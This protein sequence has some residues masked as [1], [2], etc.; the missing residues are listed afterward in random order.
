MISVLMCTYNQERYIAQA[1]ESILMQKCSEPFELLIGD[2]CST[3]ATSRIVDEYQSRYPSIVRVIRPPH[4]TG[5]AENIIRLIHEAKYELIAICDGDDYWLRDD[6]L[7]KHLQIYK[8]RP[9]VGMICAKAKC[10]IQEKDIYEG[11]LGYAGAEDLMTML[12]DNRDIA[13]PTYSYR[14]A[15][16]LKCIAECN[17]YTERNYFYDTIQAYWFAY[18]SKIIYIE[19]ELAAYR[20][21]PNSS[22]HSNDSEKIAE[23]GRR[24]FAVKWHFIMTHPDLCDEEMY[25]ILS[26]DYDERSDYMKYIG[27]CKVVSSKAYRLG[28]MIV[29]PFKK[30]KTTK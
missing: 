23:Y 30:L 11:T 9:D 3:D 26:R 2:D 13:A 19:E 6:V 27:S 21:L 12:R 18:H 10:Y 17:W 20:V 28:R 16:M 14:K 24:Y 4:N 25:E 5:A 22:S 7:Q 8:T 29:N 15:L 1:I